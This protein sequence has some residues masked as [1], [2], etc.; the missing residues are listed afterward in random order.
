MRACSRGLLEC[1]G[2]RGSGFRKCPFYQQCSEMGGPG[3]AQ[4]TEDACDDHADGWRCKGSHRVQCM[5]LRTVDFQLCP[6]F[7]DCQDGKDGRDAQCVGYGEGSVSLVSWARLGAQLPGQWG[8]NNGPEVREARQKL[9]CRNWPRKIPPCVVVLVRQKDGW[10]VCVPS[11]PSSASCLPSLGARWSPRWD[12][13]R[14]RHPPGGGVFPTGAAGGRA[15]GGG[16]GYTLT[17]LT[18]VTR[19]SLNLRR[20]RCLARLAPGSIQLRH[21]QRR[22]WRRCSSRFG[23]LAGRPPLGLPAPALRRASGGLSPQTSPRSPRSTPHTTGPS[24]RGCCSSSQR[25]S[26]PPRDGAMRARIHIASSASAGRFASLVWASAVV[27]TWLE[28]TSERPPPVWR[29]SGRSQ[30][31]SP[32]DLSGGPPDPM[33]HARQSERLGLPECRR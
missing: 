22:P 2:G 8:H 5:G 30:A 10:L 19:A 12:V 7:V 15:D 17:R 4:C 32:I 13:E 9:V 23:P 24:R 1:Q 27:Q 20:D 6:D 3:A 31:H 25:R 14:R 26:S 28:R 18:R 16:G 11:A 21:V 33:T 29:T